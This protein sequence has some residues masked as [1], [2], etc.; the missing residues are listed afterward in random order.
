MSGVDL[1][2]LT[3][4]H[5]G[6]GSVPGKRHDD[7]FILAGRRGQGPGENRVD[8]SLLRAEVVRIGR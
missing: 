5:Q 3:M 7:L 4:Q 2:S 1:F 6:L 8:Y